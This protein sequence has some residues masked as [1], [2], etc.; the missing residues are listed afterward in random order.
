MPPART[1]DEWMSL[2]CGVCLRKSNFKL[3]NISEAKIKLIRDYHYRRLSTWD[4]LMTQLLRW[5]TQTCWRLNP[6]LALVVRPHWKLLEPSDLSLGGKEWSLDWRSSWRTQTTSRRVSTAAR[7]QLSRRKSRRQHLLLRGQRSSA[8]IS[9][10]LST[11][12]WRKESE[13]LWRS[14]SKVIQAV[15]SKGTAYNCTGA[16][17]TGESQ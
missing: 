12:S 6:L 14:P 11:V 2:I 1:H 4:T 16:R 8:Q 3:I 17:H 13:V 5:A 10:V 7:W 9:L 15:W